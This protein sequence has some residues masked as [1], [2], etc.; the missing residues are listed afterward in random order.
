[1]CFLYR[2]IPLFMG[3]YLWSAVSSPRR[4][5]SWFYLQRVS[6]YDTLC[7][8]NSKSTFWIN[9]VINSPD[10]IKKTPVFLSLILLHSNVPL[11]A[12]SCRLT[13]TWR[14]RWKLVF[15]TVTEHL[16]SPSALAAALMF[17]APSAAAESS[18]LLNCSVTKQPD[19]S[20]R[21][22]LSQPPSSSKCLTYW[23]IKNVRPAQTLTCA[24]FKE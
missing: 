18:S 15:L 24:H 14:H 8:S 1:M 3:I 7:R 17:Q 13:G 16:S 12:L 23:E 4:R 5:G 6:H 22:Q 9:M 2:M 19:G 10:F 21:Y 11:H 20:V